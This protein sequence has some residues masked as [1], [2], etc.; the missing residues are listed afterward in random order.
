MTGRRIAILGLTAAVAACATTQT[1]T[2]PQFLQ[3]RLEQADSLAEYLAVADDAATIGDQQRLALALQRIDA[4][5]ARPLNDAGEKALEDW[6]TV[7]GV[8][9]PP[10]RGRTLGPGFSSGTLGPG[11]KTMIEQ[12]FL[13]GQR[14]SIDVSSVGQAQL[15]LAV[16]RRDNSTVCTEHARRNQCNW[17]PMY[18]ERHSIELRNPGKSKVRY[19]IVID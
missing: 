10:M 17:V 7:A 14:A 13:S 11:Q 6:R 9:G 8:Q 4:R 15:T 1:G 3:A 16:K 12:T 18:T 19:Y 5:R 2:D